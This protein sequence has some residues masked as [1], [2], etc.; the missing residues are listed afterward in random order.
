LHVLSQIVDRRL[1]KT[2]DNHRAPAPFMQIKILKMLALL[3]QGDKAASLQMHPVILSC[4]KSANSGTGIGNAL[5]YECVRTSIAIHP[6]ERLLTASAAV[7][8]HFLNSSH[9]G[10]AA[11]AANNLKY[12]GLD[13]L[14][15]IVQIDASYGE[16]HQLAVIDCLEDPDE[17]LKKKTLE[18]LYRMTTTDNVEIVV[19]KMLTFLEQTSDEHIRADVATRVSELAEQYAPDN[20]WFIDTMNRVFE[21][22]GDLLKPELA[23]DLMQLIADGTGES[24]E[25]DTELR[26]SAVE[27]YIELLS[28]QQAGGKSTKM[29][30]LLLM[31]VAWV[32]GEYGTLVLSP[33]ELMELLSVGMASRVDCSSDDA[34][35]A[36]IVTAISK[37]VCRSGGAADGGAFISPLLNSRSLDL[38]QRAMETANLAAHAETHVWGPSSEEIEFDTLFT[39]GLDAYV[40]QALANGAAPYLDSSLRDTEELAKDVKDDPGLL[41][42]HTE[43]PAPSSAAMG[44][45]S[46]LGLGGPSPGVMLGGIE[47][48]SS[49]LSGED[50]AAL[51]QQA[52]AKPAPGPQLNVTSRKWGR[53]APQPAAPPPS[54]VPA[55]PEQHQAAASFSHQHQEASYVPEPQLVHEEEHEPTEREALA[56]SLFGSNR[57]SGR[58]RRR[59]RGNQQPQPQ[60]QQQALGGRPQQQQN[61]DLL[62]L[63]GGGTSQPAQPPVPQQQQPVPDL[64]DLGSGGGSSGGASGADALADLMGGGPVNPTSAPPNMMGGGMGGGGMGMMGMGMGMGMGG[65]GMAQQQAQQKAPMKGPG[66]PTKPKDPFQD[67]LM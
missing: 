35:K 3:G 61:P 7:V 32:L 52:Q 42:Q 22:A 18:L 64:L 20:H 28:E 43:D 30:R 56:A 58:G 54:A 17:T 51:A 59:G 10:V 9:A 55:Q 1:P 48:L 49:I 4:L 38:Q 63:M 6:D 46:D 34:V 66:T 45:M 29:P 19:D 67:L 40:Q 33:A 2:Y 16:K 47:P 36:F 53:P 13:A 5:V 26:K 41:Y 25:V 27:S 60:Q 8:A 57:G 12:V 50:S 62:D 44:G 39:Q 65:G 31:I 24:E 37:V 15:G 14:G 11:T 23:D 21:L